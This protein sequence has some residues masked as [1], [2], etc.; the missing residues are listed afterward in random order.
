MIINNLSGKWIKYDSMKLEDTKDTQK[1]I[2]FLLNTLSSS[3]TFENVEQVSY[4]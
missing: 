2:K 1:D 4:E 3:S